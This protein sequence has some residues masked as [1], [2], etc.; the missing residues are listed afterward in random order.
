MDNRPSSH[1]PSR[2]ECIS[3]IRRILMTEVL[4]NGRN[5]HFKNATD[6][7]SY[8]ES[9]YPASPSLLKQV[10]RAVREMDMPKDSRGYF[11]IN[12]THEQLRQDEDLTVMMQRT[13]AHIVDSDGCDLL[14]LATEPTY[15]SYL[16]QL[17]RES[18]TLRGKYLTIID[19]SDGI[20]FITKNRQ[21]LSDLLLRLTKDS[22]DTESDQN[23]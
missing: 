14:F 8:F 15:R 10:Q 4:E 22:S 20:L 7:M 12:K 23:P 16:L 9:L 13:H 11:I 21:A 3:A 17:I 5:D 2:A 1:N 6:F 19:T 18:E